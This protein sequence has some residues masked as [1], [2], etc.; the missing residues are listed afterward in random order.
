M[1]RFGEQ[2]YWLTQKSTPA[3]SNV[4]CTTKVELSKAKYVCTTNE[5]TFII[6]RGF[7]HVRFFTHID[8]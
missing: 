3:R 5:L 4:R 8:K 7:N 6:K 1:Y 2:I